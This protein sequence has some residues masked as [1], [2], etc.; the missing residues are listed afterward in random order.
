LHV[1][2]HRLQALL[3]DFWEVAELVH[4]AA[5]LAA[6]AECAGLARIL[7]AHGLPQLENAASLAGLS[8]RVEDGRPTAAG[9]VFL[10]Q[11]NWVCIAQRRQVPMRSTKFLSDRI[12]AR[13]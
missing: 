12:Y 7:R 1:G 6:H 9:L 8:P 13:D 5:A 11:P 2:D 10:H 3:A 4:H